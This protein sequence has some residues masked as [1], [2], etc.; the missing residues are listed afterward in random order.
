MTLVHNNIKVICIVSDGKSVG[1]PETKFVGTASEIAAEIRRL[2]LIPPHGYVLPT[3]P[4]QRQ[5]EIVVATSQTSPELLAP[6]LVLDPVLSALNAAGDIS[7]DY[8]AAKL[9][10]ASVVTASEPAAALKA[11]LLDCYPQA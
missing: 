11:E 8:T 9:A 7:N 10:L 6:Y 3:T 4:G 5:R 2:N 1:T